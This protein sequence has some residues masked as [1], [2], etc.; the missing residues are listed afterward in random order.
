LEN[1]MT[2]GIAGAA[3]LALV[4]AAITGCS[5]EYDH[6]DAV[7]HQFGSD[8][9]SA[10]GML[11]LTEPV[12]G[13][14]F[15]AGG[16][17]AI[18]TEVRGDLIAAGGELSLGGAVDDDLYAAGGNVQLDAIVKGNARVAGGDVTVGSATV[19]AGALSLT[20]GRVQFDGNTHEHLQATGGSV[21]LNGEVHGDVEVRSEELLI[22]PTTRIGGKLTYR[23]PVAPTVPEGAVVAGG[24]DFRESRAGHFFNGRGSHR[25]VHEAT[26]TVGSVLW[27]LG[28]FVAAALFLLVFPRF[29]RDAASAV[30]RKPLQSVGLGLAVAACVPFVAVV[31]LITVIG[32]PLALLLVPIYL[33]T[34]FL[35][36]ATTALFLAQRGTE[37]LR[38]GRV[39]AL[40]G[41]L[42]ALFLALVALWLVGK[43]PLVGGLITLLALLAGIGALVWQAWQGRGPATPTAAPA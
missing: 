39:P 4:L 7:T 8:Y 10:G 9:F 12:E 35:G 6:D 32:I 21:R 1:A 26:H 13:D 19:V 3:L 33:L 31:L 11:N 18:A 16:R 40:A 27:F 23:G 37:A 28:V 14:A 29:A 36:W 41:Q 5:V 2:R 25:P 20:G 15:L 17:V 38:P 24:I 22:G 30:G 42:A 34:L 43:I